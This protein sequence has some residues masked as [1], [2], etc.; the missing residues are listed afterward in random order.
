[1]FEIII[2]C[3]FE[4]VNKDNPNVFKSTTIQSMSILRIT[5]VCACEMGESFYS[6]SKNEKNYDFETGSLSFFISLTRAVSGVLK[7][8]LL[9]F[10]LVVLIT[11]YNRN[12]NS[13]QP[14]INKI[15]TKTEK[16]AN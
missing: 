9:I 8:F 5:G 7:Y 1:M 6:V 14:H 13:K 10:S 15:F 16:I 2:S 3:D 12:I 4:K 11:W